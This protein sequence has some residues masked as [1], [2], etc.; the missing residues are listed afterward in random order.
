MLTSMMSETQWRREIGTR[1][2]MRRG[3]YSV[4]ASDASGVGY[5]I[6]YRLEK[7][8]NVNVGL[9]HLFML[10]QFFGCGLAGLIDPL[11]DVV[12]EWPPAAPSWPTTD[13]VYRHRLRERRRELRMGAKRLG[14]LAGV[15][16]SWIFRV[17]SGEH[18]TL[19][20]IRLARVAA[21]LDCRPS[22]F[23][24]PPLR[25]EAPACPT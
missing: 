13:E 15:H 14:K 6:I 11:D 1:L 3:D 23:L 18:A 5:Q 19:D 25:P 21:A 20:V 9:D 7:A 4:H 17:E 22:C 10:A 12:G 8:R 2:A 16:C 24:P